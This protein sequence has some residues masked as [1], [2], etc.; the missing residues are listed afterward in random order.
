MLYCEQYERVRV[1]EQVP[2]IN[3]AMKIT[4]FLELQ[5]DT[6]LTDMRL[7][8]R[9]YNILNVSYFPLQLIFVTSF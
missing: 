1:D 8:A 6:T 5:D 3:H 4:P 7:T 2:L 9:I